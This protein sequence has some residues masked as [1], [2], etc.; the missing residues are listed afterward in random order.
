MRPQGR[1]LIREA[2]ASAAVVLWAAA[3]L[4]HVAPGAAAAA[5]GQGLFFGIAPPPPPPAGDGAAD[6]AGTQVLVYD[7]GA[8]GLVPGDAPL[9][10][11]LDEWLRS[12]GSSLVSELRRF[13][14]IGRICSLKGLVTAMPRVRHD[15]CALYS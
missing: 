9:N 11:W 13:S 14:P 5:F 12:R 15:T 10:A 1:A 3:L 7:S 8:A 4:P 2:L 6:A